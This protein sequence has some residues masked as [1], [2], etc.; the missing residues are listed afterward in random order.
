[1]FSSIYHVI[2]MRAEFPFLPTYH[3]YH[4]LV[5]INDNTVHGVFV[6]RENWVMQ[7]KKNTILCSDYC[8]L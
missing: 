7:C 8:V 2:L 3:L 4:T 6:F 5:D 1:M